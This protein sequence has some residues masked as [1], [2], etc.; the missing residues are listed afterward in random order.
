MAVIPE[1]VPVP[2]VSAGDSVLGEHRHGHLLVGVGVSLALVVAPL[3]H[4]Q[5]GNFFRLL[6]KERISTRR[7]I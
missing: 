3:H 6:I 4:L 7:F 1:S 2:Q 5:D